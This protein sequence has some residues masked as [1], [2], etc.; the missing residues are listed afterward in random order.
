MLFLT[1]FSQYVA[2]YWQGQQKIGTSYI[3]TTIYTFFVYSKTLHPNVKIKTNPVLQ[4]IIN[5][6]ITITYVRP[7]TLVFS[8]WQVCVSI[9]TTHYMYLPFPN[10]KTSIFFSNIRERREGIF[11]NPLSDMQKQKKIL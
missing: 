4:C 3:Y 2:Q 1:I 8:E 6:P 10:C 7:T 9:Q 11:L 5:H